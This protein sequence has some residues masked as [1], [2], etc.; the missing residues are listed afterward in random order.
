LRGSEWQIREGPNH[1]QKACMSADARALL[2]GLDLIAVDR[3]A[4]I[5]AFCSNAL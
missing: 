1:A 4:R 5:G 2:A 3:N